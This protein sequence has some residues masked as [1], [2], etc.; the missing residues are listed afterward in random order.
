M[1]N[2]QVKSSKSFHVMLDSISVRSVSTDCAFVTPLHGLVDCNREKMTSNRI[3]LLSKVVSVV[4]WRCTGPMY[5]SCFSIP[6]IFHTSKPLNFICV[7]K[8]QG[9]N[10]N[11]L[12]NLCPIDVPS[13]FL[14]E[15]LQIC[16]AFDSE[17]NRI[18][19]FI[20]L[21]VPQAWYNLIN[22][23]IQATLF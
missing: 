19:Q 10:L 11:V 6:I 17:Y 7:M 4:M 15:S 16:P 23:D 12:W 2:A 13:I 3:F 22:P 5:I 9:I 8:G 20:S 1:K 21:S 14:A 18:L